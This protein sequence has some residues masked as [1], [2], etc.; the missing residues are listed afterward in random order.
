M[1]YK[2]TVANK[3]IESMDLCKA[4]FYD[5][6]NFNEKDDINDTTS[7]IN[8]HIYPYRFIPDINSTKKTYITMSFRKFQLINNTFKS[9][10]MYINILTHRDLSS[11]DYGF[12]RV[13]FILSK[14]DELFNQKRGF[15]LG[16]LEFYDMDEIYVNEKYSGAY[17][18]YKIID[19][20]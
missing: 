1:N 9:G 3:L 6:T 13:D 5:D 16:K 11:T 10:L 14:I 12:T 19:F 17:I 2:N 4:V 20:N 7:L 8:N 18:A 15:G